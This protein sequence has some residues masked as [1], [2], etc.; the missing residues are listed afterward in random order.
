MLRGSF[1]FSIFALL[2]LAACSTAPHKKFADVKPGMY[3][4]DVLD[5]LGSPTE[6][7]YRGDQY[8]WTY[9][10]MTDDKNVVKEVHVKDDFVT[11]AGEPQ[12]MASD[13]KISRVVTGMTKS[14]VLDVMGF[15]K[16]TQKRNGK[17]AWVYNSKIGGE[18]QVQFESDKVVHVGPAEEPAAPAPAA[19]EVAKPAD[20]AFEPVE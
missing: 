20:T 11:Y 19:Q 3:K 14:Q 5:M 6:S 13:S 15:P 4:G 2:S 1:L 12:P 18:A 16:R 7:R 17:D 9:K 10:F 8:I